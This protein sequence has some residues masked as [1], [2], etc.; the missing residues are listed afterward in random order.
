VDIPLN[1]ETDW[2]SL[3]APAGALIAFSFV[4]ADFRAL[5]DSLFA[6]LVPATP[7]PSIAQVDRIATGLRAVPRGIAVP[8]ILGG[9][10]R[11]NPLR[12]DTRQVLISAAR[13]RH[14]VDMMYDGF[15]RLVKPYKLEYYVRKSD[16]EGSEYF[17][18]FDTSGGKSGEVSPFRAPCKTRRAPR[19]HP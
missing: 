3:L 6:L 2:P 18:G 12:A 11:V 7:V 10:G 8:G 13:S 17:W 19:T 15:R 4:T 1:Y 5:I 16:G 9:F 14:M